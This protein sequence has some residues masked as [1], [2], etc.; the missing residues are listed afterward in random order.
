MWNPVWNPHTGP[1][2]KDD[3]EPDE[4]YTAPHKRVRITVQDLKR[5]GFSGFGPTCILHRAGMYAEA[6]TS[7]HSGSRRQR[8][9]ERLKMD[10]SPKIALARKQG[11]A[12]TN[13]IP[14]WYPLHSPLPH[15]NPLRRLVMRRSRARFSLDAGMGVD[16]VLHDENYAPIMDMMA[17]LGGGQPQ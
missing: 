5:Y 17:A 11:R 12:T 9:Y 2:P 14:L 7:K 16:T 4:E 6:N 3:G 13:A 15:P 1:V 8:I 10:N